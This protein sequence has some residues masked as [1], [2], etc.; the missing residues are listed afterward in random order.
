MNYYSVPQI[1]VDGITI[2]Y[3]DGFHCQP[4]FGFTD[5]QVVVIEPG[6]EHSEGRY[7]RFLRDSDLC[8]LGRIFSVDSTDEVIA[9][10]QMIGFEEISVSMCIRLC[11]EAIKKSIFE[12]S[13]YKCV[14][15]S[16]NHQMLQLNLQEN[17]AIQKFRSIIGESL[18][19]NG[20][21]L[22][23]SS[24]DTYTLYHGGDA[25]DD[26]F[27]D[28][29]AWLTED[30][31]YAAHYCEGKETPCIWE[32]TIDNSKLHT[33]SLGEIGDDFD[34]Y[35]GPSEEDK[36]WM[37]ENGYNGYE[38]PVSWDGYETMCVVLLDD[39]AVQSTTTLDNEEVLSL[40]K[41]EGIA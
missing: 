29:M 13:T 16:N 3:N 4:F 21:I 7:K 10:Y 36:Q 2:Q 22:N 34:P 23:E 8:L 37:L 9:V 14:N 39:S 11:K 41:E 20:I 31:W 19:V 24:A 18:R 26:L 25:S 6:S 35:D 38:F 40:M 12:G 28:G 15:S 32:V 30:S 1:Q 5:G 27:H 33:A 17:K